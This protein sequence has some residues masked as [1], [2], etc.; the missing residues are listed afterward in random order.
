[1]KRAQFSHEN[2]VRLLCVGPNKLGTGEDIRHFSI[3]PNNL[4]IE[5]A[6][7]PRLISFER[8][9]R[10]QALRALGYAGQIREDISY[11]KVLNLIP[12]PDWPEPEPDDPTRET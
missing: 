8:L 1:M 4:F 11:A 10:E 12:L 6:F 3:D 2:E 7:D 5:I 9:E